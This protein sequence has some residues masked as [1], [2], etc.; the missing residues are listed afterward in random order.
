MGKSDHYHILGVSKDASDEDI[1]KASRKMTVTYHPDK[2]PRD[3]VAEENF[4]KLL[5]HTKFST[6]AT[7]GPPM[8]GT[9]IVP[10]NMEDEHKLVDEEREVS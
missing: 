9:D 3:K 10:S 2:N 7:N 5:K 1:N 8:I 6:I 4:T